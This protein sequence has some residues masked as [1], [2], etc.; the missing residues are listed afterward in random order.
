MSFIQ[1]QMAKIEAPT[2]DDLFELCFGAEY[3]VSET[4]VGS[5]SLSCFDICNEKLYKF[6]YD[7]LPEREWYRCANHLPVNEYDSNIWEIMAEAL[8]YHLK[9]QF[10]LV[11][12]TVSDARRKRFFEEKIAPL[13]DD[14]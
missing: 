4:D 3:S 5:C 9:D 12:N 14:T 7:I 6:T 2:I 13:N 11:E 10:D 1:S 8:A